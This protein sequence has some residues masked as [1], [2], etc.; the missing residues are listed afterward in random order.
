M[1]KRLELKMILKN[2]EKVFQNSQGCEAQ[3]PIL[4]WASS[5]GVKRNATQ[6]LRQ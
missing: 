3:I 1:E 5:Y 6:A 4:K 2:I